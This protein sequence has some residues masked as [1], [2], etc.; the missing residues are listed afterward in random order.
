[1]EIAAHL[2]YKPFVFRLI[3]ARQKS[4][5][6]YTHL[7]TIPFF[8]AEMHSTSASGGGRARKNNIDTKINS[9]N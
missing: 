9:N 4:I 1:M 7:L 8:L 3:P 2:A 5:M 6:I